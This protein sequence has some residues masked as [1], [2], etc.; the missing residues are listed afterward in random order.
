LLTMGLFSCTEEETSGTSG[1]GSMLTVNRSF[2]AYAIVES[3]NS[4]RPCTLT[5]R[6]PEKGRWPESQPIPI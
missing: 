4:P 1:Q 5:T 6:R 2:N 3:C